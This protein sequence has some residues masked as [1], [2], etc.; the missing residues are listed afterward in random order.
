VGEMYVGLLCDVMPDATTKNE[1]NRVQQSL[2]REEWKVCEASG[3]S[4]VAWISL[5]LL[6]GSNSSEDI[7]ATK[8]DH[9]ASVF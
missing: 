1:T 5:S 8:P 6:V 4:L 9:H 3:A 2:T 7:D